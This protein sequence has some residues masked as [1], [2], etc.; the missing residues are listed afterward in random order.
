MFDFKD[1]QTVEQARYSLPILGSLPQ[2]ALDFGRTLFG[3]ASCWFSRYFSYV[4]AC[5][6]RDVVNRPGFISVF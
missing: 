5:S 3:V 4:L 6:A 2:S 1:P